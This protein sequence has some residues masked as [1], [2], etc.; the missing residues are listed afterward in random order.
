MKCVPKVNGVYWV[1]LVVAS[2]FGADTGDLLADGL[3]LG[4]LK[5]LPLLAAGLALVFVAERF[6]KRTSALYFWAA[7]V[8][9]TAAASN[10]ADAFHD[11]H[12]RLASV[13]LMALL[14]AFVVIVWRS[15]EA[16]TEEQ[17]FIP[18]NGLYW[19][20]LFLAAVLGSVA[21]DAA[22]YPL[23]FGNMGTVA[24]CAV[25]LMFLL[26]IGR[27]G[28]YADLGFYWLVMVFIV[29]VGTAAGDLLTQLLHSVDRSAVVSGLVFLALIAVAYEMR[30]GNKSLQVQTVSELLP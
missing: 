17:G 3:G 12:V 18:V 29:A 30:K 26:F 22:S 4:H 11:F 13:P 16:S 23:G 27:K 8:I 20:T 21:G 28:L 9:G 19:F 24:V 1:S 15:R 2:L 7:V 14:L 10:V 6:F 5:G 25:P